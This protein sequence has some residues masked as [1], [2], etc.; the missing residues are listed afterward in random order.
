MAA[1]FSLREVREASSRAGRW[2][3]RT[4]VLTSRCLDQLAGRQLFFKAEN[5][6]K[7]G[8]FKARGACN[9]VFIEKENNPDSP[10]VVTHSTGNHGQAVAYAAKCAGLPCSVVVPKDT[11]KVKCSAIEGYG[12]KLVFCEPSPQARKETCAAIANEMGQT[13]I[14]PYDDYRV[15]AGQATIA[16]ELLEEVPDLDAILVPISGGG[17]T[18]GIAVAAQ[19]MQPNCKVF[20]VEPVGKDLQR[21]LEKGEKIYSGPNKFLDTVADS[22]RIQQVGDLT[23]PIL[24]D[25]AEHKVFTITDEQ[26]VEGMKLTFERLKMVVEVASGAAVYAALHRLK[27]VSPPPQ[28][29]G[30][31]LCGG[32]VDLDR[33]PW[34]T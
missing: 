28:K 5:L 17:M 27:E 24:C 14:H 30:V 26:M 29:V 6:Q 8:S 9:A 1:P 15:M 18:S 13:I 25:F 2:L 10:G 19:E 16:L 12:A 7:T 3:H 20:A 23:F 11:P 33:L 22:I 21:C 34:N 31:I 32:N 4:P